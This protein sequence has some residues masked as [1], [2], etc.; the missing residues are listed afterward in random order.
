MRCNE[1]CFI[2]SEEVVWDDEDRDG[3]QNI[4][5]LTIQPPDMAA[6]LRIFYWSW[7]RSSPLV[8]Q[9]QISKMYQSLQPEEYGTLVKC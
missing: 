1:I 7:V 5:L 6:S 9:H 4:G 8:L 3:P 2:F